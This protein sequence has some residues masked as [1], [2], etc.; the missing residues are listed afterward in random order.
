MESSLRTFL[1]FTRPPKL[2]RRSVQ[3]Q[4][5]LQEVFGLVRGRAEKQKV[6]MRLAADEK[7]IVVIADAE[8]L[9]QVLVNLVLNSLDALPRGGTIVVSAKTMPDHVEICVTDSGAGISADMLPHLFQPFS[10]NKETGLGLG[11][12]I[13]KRIVEDHGGSIEAENTVTGGA[14]FRV[15]LPREK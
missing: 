8:Q 5:V 4:N 12:V 2:E 1:D 15:R 3:L 6:E 9:R 13:S 11:L 10:S 7:N 14:A